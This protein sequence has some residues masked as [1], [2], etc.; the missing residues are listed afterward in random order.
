M[1]QN[2]TPPEEKRNERGV[3]LVWFALIL[4]VLMGMAGFAVDLSNWW[5]QA[6]KIQRAADAG[7]HGGVVFLPGDLP[8]AT[9]T[10]NREVRKNGY[11]VSGSGSGNPATVRV[12]QEP[13]P[14]RLRVSVT[15][16]VPNHF[17]RIFGIPS[18]TMTREAVAEYVAPVPMGSPE[19]K[20]GNDPEGVDPGAQMWVNISGTN[21]GKQ[22]GDR[23]QSRV[24]DGSPREVECTGSVNDEYDEDGY[25]FAMDV[26]AIKPGQPLLFQVYDAAFVNVGFS[27]ESRMPSSTQINGGGGTTGLR[28]KFPDAATRYGNTPSYCSGDGH[29]A[30]PPMDTT[31]IFREPDDTPWS[32]TDNP[33][34]NTSRCQP[35]T[36]PGHNPNS[37]NYIYNLLMDPVEGR[38]DP[39][40]GVISFAEA[41]RRFS[42]LCEIPAGQVRTGK[43]I[44]QVRTNARPGTPLQ[45]TPSVVNYGHNKMAFRAGFGSSGLHDVDGSHVTIAALGRLPLFANSTGADTRF[46][47][48]RVMPYDA[49]RTLR[50]SLFDMGEGSRPGNLQILPPEEFASTFSGCAFARDDGATLD[51]TTSVCRLNNVSSSSYNGRSLTIDVPIPDGYDCNTELPTGCWVK[52]RASYPAGTSVTDAT[53]WSAVILGNP[54]RLVE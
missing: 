11:R 40:D 21:T 44:I 2:P 24:C 22:Q 6:D 12:M 25:F 26:K 3:V 41:F 20:L 37:N 48:A 39:N 34:I 5:L 8:S 38:L 23:Y 35:V 15:T 52:I 42:T 18:T 28:T 16:E 30:N 51:T 10:A 14:N 4:F 45:Y 7:A 54:I 1:S 43:Y 27:C 47:M 32:S 53:T 17:L 19:N 9:A 29:G 49:G 13:N 50:I 33:V 31:F 36:V 46:H